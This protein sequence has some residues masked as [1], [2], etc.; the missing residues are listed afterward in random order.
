MRWVGVI[1]I[2]LGAGLISYSEQMKEEACRSVPSPPRA[3]MQP[4]ANDGGEGAGQ[5]FGGGL[6]ATLELQQRADFS[7]R[8]H[9]RH[10]QP[11]NS[12]ACRGSSAG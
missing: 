8:R 3:E 6:A 1:L 11:G 4:P 9:E 12:S 2:V 5:R 10:G 7:R